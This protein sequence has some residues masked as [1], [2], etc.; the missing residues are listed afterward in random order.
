MK[1]VERIISLVIVVAMFTTVMPFEINAQTVDDAT[2]QM[3]SNEIVGNEQLDNEAASFAK[4]FFLQEDEEI[5]LIEDNTLVLYRGDTGVL[6]IASDS[7]TPVPISDIDCSESSI[8]E[9]LGNGYI[10]AKAI[11]EARITI[12]NGDGDNKIVINI[13]IIEEPLQQQGAP[14]IFY[15]SQDGGQQIIDLSI[16]LALLV[17]DTGSITAWHEDMATPV[18]TRIEDADGCLEL[19]SD[20]IIQT[21]Q[22]GEAILVVS[23]PL[24]E[25]SS[26]SFPV[27]VDPARVEPIQEPAYTMDISELQTP[28]STAKVVAS[29]ATTSFNDIKKVSDG[30]VVV[31]DISPN[32]A[33][34]LGLTG[35]GGYLDAFIAKYDYDGSMVWCQNFGGSRTDSFNSLTVSSQGYV[36]AGYSGSKD[37]DMESINKG[38]LSNDGNDGIIV[39]YSLDGDLLWKSCIGGS[40]REYGNNDTIF[41]VTTGNGGYVVCGWTNST[42]GDFEDKRIGSGLRGHDDA[43][44]AYINENGNLGWVKCFGGDESEILNDVVAVADGYVAVGYSYS[45]NKDMEGYVGGA[46]AV[47]YSFEGN[48]QW[49]SRFGGLTSRGG[50]FYSVTASTDGGIVAVGQSGAE[51]GD[52]AEIFKGSSSALIVKYD[53]DGN[54]KWANSFGGTNGTG[55]FHSLVA[56]YDGFVAVG[57]TRASDGD[58]QGIRLDTSINDTYYADG[59]LARYDANG[60]LSWKKC[61]GGNRDDILYGV[62]VADYGFVAVG[63]SYSTDMDLESLNLSTTTGVLAWFSEAPLFDE[64]KFSAKQKTIYVG[65]TAFNAPSVKVSGLFV[66]LKGTENRISWS[67]SN[68]DIATVNPNSGVIT[69]MEQGQTTIRVSYYGNVATYILKVQPLPAERDAYIINKAGATLQQSAGAVGS[70]TKIDYL[71]KVTVLSRARK[72]VNSEYWVQISFSGDVGWIKF[73]MIGDAPPA[74]SAPGTPQGALAFAQTYVG[75]Q[76]PGVSSWGRNSYTYAHCTWYAYERF[77]QIYGFYPVQQSGHDTLGHGGSW[78]SRIDLSHTYST[79]KNLKLLSFEDAKKSGT[80]PEQSILSMAYTDYTNGVKTTYGHVAIIEAYDKEKGLVYLSESNRFTKKYFITR[81]SKLSLKDEGLGTVYGQYGVLDRTDGLVVEMT[82][83]DFWTYF[84]WA[85]NVHGFICF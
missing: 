64:M 59:V 46:V 55:K 48:L 67:S 61:F 51:D 66:S 73:S 79:G 16:G 38:G 30:Y 10:Y 62:D 77:N 71:S 4:V 11:G 60:N 15:E 52:M 75:Q 33:S 8:V 5:Q 65:E 42:N 21:M 13:I 28:P 6:L 56:D 36:A 32:R 31:G 22:T 7:E 3:R 70:S 24:L 35:K 57:E 53:S 27:V 34:E 45:T 41:G 80:I 12:K 78:Y 2:A 17:G 49:V 29:I 82:V 1:S 23:F 26:V 43:F 69:A 9:V 20:S 63:E 58:L 18:K 40:W 68:P 72:L 39:K 37:A 81:D 50:E 47:K 83:Q 19:N 84:S 44:V 74:E 76:V 25:W 14:I 54:K 85:D